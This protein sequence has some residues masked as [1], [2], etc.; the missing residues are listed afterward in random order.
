MTLNS[1]RR[2]ALD[3]DCGS[4]GAIPLERIFVRWWALAFPESLSTRRAPNANVESSTA[5]LGPVSHLVV[6]PGRSRSRECMGMV[7]QGGVVP[8][9]FDERPFEPLDE[10]YV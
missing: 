7:S 6:V 8:R 2:W 1:K 9:T 4:A 10:K 5:V 3:E